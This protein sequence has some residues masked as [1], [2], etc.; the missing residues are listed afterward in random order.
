M[1]KEKTKDITLGG[2]QFRLTKISAIDGSA[3]LRLFTSQGKISV[4]QFVSNLTSEQFADL[5]RILLSKIFR[6]EIVNEKEA[7]S[8]VYIGDGMIDPKIEDAQTIFML[9]I[10]SLSF[11]LSG[12]FEEST[13]KEF[14]QIMDQFNV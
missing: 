12:F 11:N 1:V 9:T 8:P 4:Q 7:L 2:N 13:L 6:L 5:Q 3:L 10:I 14:G